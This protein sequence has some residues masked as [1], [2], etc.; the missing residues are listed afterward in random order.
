MCGGQKHMCLWWLGLCLA[1]CASLHPG[2]FCISVS[3]VS[4]CLCILGISAPQASLNL[5]PGH[6]CILGISASH[7][8]GHLHLCIPASQV[9]RQ[10]GRRAGVQPPPAQLGCRRVSARAAESSSSQ[11]LSLLSKSLTTSFS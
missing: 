9:Q 3:Q 1:R 5:C 10:P 4:L 2:H 7:H 8:P 11:M 6:L